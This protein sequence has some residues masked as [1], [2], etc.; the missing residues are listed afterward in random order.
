MWAVILF[1]NLS[2]GRVF[3]F[4]IEY[5]DSMCHAVLLLA[6][7]CT[8][9]AASGSHAVSGVPSIEDLQSQW[10]DPNVDVS[11]A[12]ALGGEQRDLA[13]INNF[14]VRCLA[15]RAITAFGVSSV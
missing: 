4:E 11:K 7:A 2:C 8:L 6:C 13:T 5:P 9:H 15:T 3:V 1:L 12:A 14:W 10:M